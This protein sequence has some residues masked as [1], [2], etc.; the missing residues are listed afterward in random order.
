MITDKQLLKNQDLVLK[1]S[2]NVDPAKFDVS[3]YEDFLDALCRDRDYQKDA[4]RETLRYLLGG[5]YNSLRDLARENYHQN[6]VLQ[7]QVYSS[8]EDFYKSSRISFPA[9]WI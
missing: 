1:V 4:I 3:K 2:P 5:Q 9:P 8:F 6:P 7:Q